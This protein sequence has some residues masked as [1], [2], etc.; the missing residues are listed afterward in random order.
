MLRLRKAGRCREKKP[1]AGGAVTVT[2]ALALALAPAAFGEGGRVRL[3]PMLTVSGCVPFRADISFAVSW[4][5][6]L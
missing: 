6:F 1:G 4:W 3:E 2:F 5:C